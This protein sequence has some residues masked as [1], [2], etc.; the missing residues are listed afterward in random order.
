MTTAST[1]ITALGAPGTTPLLLAQVTLVLT[2]QRSEGYLCLET[3]VVVPI[4]K[5]GHV[6]RRQATTR[7]EAVPILAPALLLRLSMLLALA[8]AL[9]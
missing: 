1:A 3:L 6:M 5:H 7:R 8:R 2:V 4:F 9:R